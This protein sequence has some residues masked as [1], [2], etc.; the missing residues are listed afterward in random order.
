MSSETPP[1]QTQ[2]RILDAARKLLVETGIEGL[3]MRKVGLAAGISAAAIY[4]HFEDKDALLSAAIREGARVFV[5]YL[6]ESL[7]APSA[8]ERLYLMGRR[9]F[10]FAEEH[11]HD[12]HVLF[13]LDCEKVGLDKLDQEARAETDKS[14]QLLVDRVIE[15][16]KAGWMIPGEP[17][18]HALFIWAS[19]HGLASIQLTHRLQA[20]AAA[21]EKL[22]TKHLDH[23]MVCL[24]QLP[25]QL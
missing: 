18:E 1:L 21:Y 24:S 25:E 6:V 2:E 11:P 3:S 10:A 7:Q 13:M 15:C 5:G 4:R 9:Y 23:L 20:D 14:F 22:K 8:R 19:I 16:Q 12:Y 17:R